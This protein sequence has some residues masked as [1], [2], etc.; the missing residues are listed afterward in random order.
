MIIT[1]GV[2]QEDRS[3]R[4]ISSVS[5]QLINLSVTFR[6]LVS[7]SERGKTR[8]ERRRLSLA[9]VAKVHIMITWVQILP[10]TFPKCHPPLSFISH[11]STIRQRK[12]VT[13]KWL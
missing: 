7:Q 4:H 10:V 2:R 6:G 12:N 11:L 1:G 3:V 5:D 8:P 9:L 13:L